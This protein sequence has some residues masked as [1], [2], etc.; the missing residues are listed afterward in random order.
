MPTAGDVPDQVERLVDERVEEVVE[1][2]VDEVVDEADDAAREAQQAAEEAARAEAGDTDAM[3]GAEQARDVAVEAGVAATDAVA[4]VAPDDPVIDDAARKLEANVTED[5]P[6]GELGRPMGRRSPFRIA[7]TAALGVAAAYA[8][9]QALINVRGVIVLLVIAAFLAIGLDP[10]VEALTSRGLRR[11]GAVSIVLLAVLLVFT[12]FGLAVVP[13]VVDQGEEL[14][15]EAPTFLR[16]LENNPRIADL[17]ERYQFLDRAR[18]VLERPEDVGT[19]ALG[20]VIGIG[21]VVASA[22]FST[23]TVLILTLYF[24][25]S[26]PSIKA[27]AY[28]LVPRSRRARV[29]LLTDEIL[30]RVGG[31]LAG[32]LTIAAT[33][34]FTSFLLLL[35]L[36][37]AYPVPLAMIVSLTA[38]IPLVGATIGGTIMVGAAL[39]TSVQAG[40]ITLIFVLLYQSL[41]NYVLYPR[42]MR[43]SVDVKPAVTIVAV[44]VGGSLLGALGALL[45]IPTAAALQLVFQEVVAPRQDQL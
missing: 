1:E 18:G 21:K 5:K 6:F 9:V 29:G 14:V 22:F 15:R 25:G 26:M 8:L 23:L 33:A 45:A 32:A 16:E 13:P 36:G 27:S 19:A 12:G 30:S 24:L 3:A 2:R 7:F 40:V 41:E 17:N 10:A 20:G 42:I 43:R 38:L 31:Y 39:F 37:V 28:R 4:V 34:G 11:A 44:L 35:A